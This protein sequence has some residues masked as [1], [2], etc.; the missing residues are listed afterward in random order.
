MNKIAK[1]LHTLYMD[2]FKKNMQVLQ[3]R[4]DH[5]Y[6]PR[7]TLETQWNSD[8]FQFLEKARKILFDSQFEVEEPKKE[9]ACEDCGE[10]HEEEESDSDGTEEQI[11]RGLKVIKILQDLK[12]K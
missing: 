4:K 12:D 11:L 6:I 9:G 3:I 7:E 1:E 10:V 5:S 8:A 2:F